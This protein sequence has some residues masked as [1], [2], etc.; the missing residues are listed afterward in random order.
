MINNDWQTERAIN[1]ENRRQQHRENRSAHNAYDQNPNVY[2][3][4]CVNLSSYL[5]SHE[6]HVLYCISYEQMKWLDD[7]TPMLN[8]LRT[9]LSS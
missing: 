8:Q 7:V 5:D 2:Q 6:R 3:F 9:L 1:R 4:F